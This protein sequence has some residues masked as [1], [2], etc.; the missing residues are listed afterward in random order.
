VNA[1]IPSCSPAAGLGVTDRSLSVSRI[2]A[3]S[4]CS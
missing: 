1:F 4:H 3:V 2:S